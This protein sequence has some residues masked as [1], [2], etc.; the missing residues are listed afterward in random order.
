MATGHGSHDALP[1][2][3]GGG[4][5]DR[6]TEKIVIASIYLST[7]T[8]EKLRTMHAHDLNPYVNVA[9]GQHSVDLTR[10]QAR[11]AADALRACALSAIDAQFGA[12]DDIP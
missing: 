10:G 1:D 4:A 8:G 6:G 7:V 11:Q 3:K 5:G 9:G 2:R 12:V